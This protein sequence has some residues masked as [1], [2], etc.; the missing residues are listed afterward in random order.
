MS[1]QQSWKN[2]RI[3]T[4]LSSGYPV[5]LF[6]E[7]IETEAQQCSH[8]ESK[9]LKDAWCL[10]SSDNSSP[11]GVWKTGV[12]NSSRSFVEKKRNSIFRHFIGMASSGPFEMGI[13]NIVLALTEC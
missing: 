10:L 6:L 5:E 13:R 4:G 9:M 12:I 8:D 1:D 11:V 7:L 3:F 2:D